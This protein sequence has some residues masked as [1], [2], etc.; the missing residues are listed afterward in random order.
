MSEAVAWSVHKRFGPWC[1]IDCGGGTHTKS[2]GGWKFP[3]TSSSNSQADIGDTQRREFSTATGAAYKAL[4]Y[5]VVGYLATASI[6]VGV[7]FVRMTV[8]SLGADVPSISDIAFGK[9]S[10]GR[11]CPWLLF[12]AVA[13]ALYLVMPDLLFWARSVPSNDFY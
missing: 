13:I 10:P 1:R 3:H 9:A 11:A 6:F 5:L 2:S 7:M 8:T 12:A 4:G